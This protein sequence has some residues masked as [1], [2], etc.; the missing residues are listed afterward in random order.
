MGLVQ[1]NGTFR[2]QLAQSGLLSS[3]QLSALDDD[4]EAGPPA[5]RSLIARRLVTRGQLTQFQADR[6]LEGRAR[7]FFFDDYKILD[8]LGVGGMG[9]VYHAQDRRTGEIVALKVLSER[10]K[11]DQG[12]TARFQQEAHVGL[13]LNHPHVVRTLHLGL[14]G[15]L[16][17]MIMEFV[18]GAS[19]LE[20]LLRHKRLPWQQACEFARQA[21]LGLEHLHQLSIIHRDIKPQNLLVD[22]LGVV[23]ILDFGLAMMADGEA[24]EEFSMAMIFGHECV[25]T[26]EYSAP[27]QTEDS[28]SADARSDVYSL[29]CTLFVALTGRVPFTRSQATA[30]Q[31]KS[32]PSVRNFAPEIPEEVAAI[33]ARMLASNP[34]DRFQSAAAVA[35]ALVP[36]SEPSPASF[37]FAA[38]LAERKHHAQERF[39]QL[40][41]SA[42]G[43]ANSTAHP[44]AISSVVDPTLSKRTTREQ[45]VTGSDDSEEGPVTEP[46]VPKLG[47]LTWRNRNREIPLYG[48]QFTLG[49]KDVCDLQVADIAVSSLHCQLQFDGTYWWVVDQGSRNGT[50]VNGERVSRQLLRTGDEVVIGNQQQFRLVYEHPVIARSGS[51]HGSRHSRA[52]L[53]GLAATTTALLLAATLWWFFSGGGH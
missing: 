45:S 46:S 30:E 27:E 7:G 35:D 24:G 16:P 11:Q 37:N 6:L 48:T 42:T 15:G 38:I 26:A 53:I 36:F 17:Y 39:L 18:E 9:C 43:M 40:S 33:V 8:V 28:L 20:L 14:A 49:R 13:R 32:P 12:M 44:G 2:D 4:S 50:L 19:L 31:R 10:L 1:N 41:R 21:A 52:F 5:S 3:E 47:V 34:A 25:G 51:V 22:K 23:R 29:G